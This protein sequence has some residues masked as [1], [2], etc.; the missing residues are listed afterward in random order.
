MSVTNPPQ[1]DK[2]TLH[3][4]LYYY[5]YYPNKYGQHFGELTK[6]IRSHIIN[7]IIDIY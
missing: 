5:K 7:F 1:E 3:V 2:H 6:A 4:P